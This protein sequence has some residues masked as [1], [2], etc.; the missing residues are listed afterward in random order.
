M[1]GET[2][3][4]A[5]ST[6]G[7]PTAVGGWTAG[8]VGLGRSLSYD[9][10]STTVGE[11]RWDLAEAS[12]TTGRSTAVGGWTAGS[13]RLGRSLP[14]DG[15]IYRRWWLD[16]RIGETWPKPLVRRVDPPPLVVGRQ[17]R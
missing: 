11:D 1:I 15:S 8:S 2:L 13:V 14:Y 12:R 17:D 16:G 5:S 9:G 6:T 4:E 10:R 7:R 3:A